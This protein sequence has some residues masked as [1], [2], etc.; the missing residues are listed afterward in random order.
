MQNDVKGLAALIASKGAEQV[1]GEVDAAGRSLLHV[2]C[3]EGNL[4]ML[5]YL[6]LNYDG[7]NLDVRDRYLHL[8][9]K[10]LTV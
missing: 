2:V 4:A 10:C 3:S 6:L 5:R 8:Q 7:V 1:F 9:S